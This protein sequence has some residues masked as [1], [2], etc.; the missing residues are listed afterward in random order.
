MSGSRS[1]LIF[2]SFFKAA[3]L[4]RKTLKGLQKAW[5]TVH[6]KNHKKVR[7]LVSKCRE[8]RDSSKL[9]HR[10]LYVYLYVCIYLNIYTLYVCICVSAC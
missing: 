9:L 4:Q 8:K 1:K 5:R 10:T 7:L 3:N 2:F 6:F